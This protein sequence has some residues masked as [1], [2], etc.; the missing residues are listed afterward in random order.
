MAE[1]QLKR[2]LSRFDATVLGLRRHD[3]LGMG[4]FSPAH[5]FRSPGLAA[6]RWRSSSA[7]SAIIVI[8]LT[9]AELSSA[10]PYAGGEHAYTERAFGRLASF[11]CTWA[12][13]FGYVAVVAFEAIALPVA[14]TYLIPEFKIYPLWDIADYTVHASEAA[15]GAIGAIFITILNIIGI[16]LAARV[17]AAVVILLLAAGV[18]LLA[19]G[20]F[21]LDQI[22][23]EA[24]MWL[25]FGG[26]F[27][28]IIMVPFLFVGFDVIPQSA[29][30]IGGSM[31]GIGKALVV[32]IIAAVLFYLLI[33]FS[34]G[35]A[36]LDPDN[37]N[38]ATADAA[39][40][41]WQS[42][43]A[44]GL[45]HHRRHW[46]HIDELERIS[47]RRQPGVVRHGAVWSVA[48]IFERGASAVW[49]AMDGH[50]I[51]RRPF[52]DCTAIRSQRFGVGRERRRIWHCH[53]LCFRR[54]GVC[55]FTHQGA[56]P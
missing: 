28:V 18:V 40:A 49:H 47:H 32:S 48:E 36:P 44:A 46:R 45:C 5:G 7:P 24:P 16:R 56:R 13:I 6:R 17:Q 30:E 55:L 1:Q 39:G 50:C 41:W 35:L 19:G 22:S 42:K 20:V 4:Q 54:G 21:H 23:A 10:L 52:C 53:R 25:G 15:L 14:V 51:D 33:V 12:I 8:G 9:Y 37:V 29:E 2:V 34:V 31:R 3:R 38:I 11:V 27:S 43:T 26:V